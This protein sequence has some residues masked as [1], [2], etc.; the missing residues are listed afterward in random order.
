MIYH[1]VV[2]APLIG[3]RCRVDA[4]LSLHPGA[5]Q[6]RPYDFTSVL[7]D[8]GVLAIPEQWQEY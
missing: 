1:K 3:A 5:N 4:C 2:G 6:W 7:F 8:L